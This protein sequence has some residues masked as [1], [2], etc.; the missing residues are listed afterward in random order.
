MNKM[1]SQSHKRVFSTH[2]A[3]QAGGRWYLTFPG[4]DDEMLRGVGG[5]GEIRPLP[6]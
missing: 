4:Q 5:G 1:K 6:I 3:R 2:V